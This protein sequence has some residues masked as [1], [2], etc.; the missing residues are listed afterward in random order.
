ME[1]DRPRNPGFQHREIK[2]QKPLAVKSVG[3]A[4]AEETP[5]HTGEF[6]G[7]THRVLEHT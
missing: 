3:N 6:T 4:S 5:R 7:E 1:G 2:P